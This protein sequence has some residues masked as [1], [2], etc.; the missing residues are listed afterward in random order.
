VVAPPIPETEMTQ[1]IASEILEG[2]VLVQDKVEA[3]VGLP[4]TRY[5]TEPL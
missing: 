4:K 1:T 3:V 2:F 5:D